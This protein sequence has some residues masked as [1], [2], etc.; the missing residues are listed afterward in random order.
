MPRF[1]DLCDIFCLPSVHE[2]WGLAINE[3][4]ACGKPVIVSDEVG[5]QPDL[6]RDG[7]TGLVFPAKNVEALAECLRRVAEDPKLAAQLT[8]AGRQHI[9]GWSFDADIAGLWAA[10]RGLGVAGR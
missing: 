7:E 5:C 1:Y 10:I 3:V 6:V 2:P 4:M 8:S 9:A